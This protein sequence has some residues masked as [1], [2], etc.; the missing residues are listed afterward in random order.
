MVKQDPAH[1]EPLA[2]LCVAGRVKIHIDRV[3]ALDQVPAAPARVGE[4]RALGKVVVTV[5]RPDRREEC[6]TVADMWCL[7]GGCAV[8][9]ESRR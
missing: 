3:F 7:E 9:G 4:G 6:T 1:G 2:G 5:T 8:D